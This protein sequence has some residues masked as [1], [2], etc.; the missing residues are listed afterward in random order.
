[1]NDNRKVE[2]ILFE[3]ASNFTKEEL[4]KEQIKKDEVDD[5]FNEIFTNCVNNILNR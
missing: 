4:T 1:M 3:Y 2:Y 5:K